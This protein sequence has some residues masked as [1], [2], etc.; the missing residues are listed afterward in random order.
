M[1]RRWLLVSLP[2][3]Q[4]G[5]Q[6][7]GPAMPPPQPEIVVGPTVHVSTAFGK[8]SHTEVF[9]AAH[10]SIPGLLLACAMRGRAAYDSSR[11]GW[12]D[13]PSYEV[14]VYRSADGGA[15]WAPTLD[16]PGG[17]PSCVFGH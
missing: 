3:L 10:P 5:G 15:T 1:R 12:L 7:P 13:R 16:F 11:P 8:Q 2:L 14:V 4:L 17:D 6:P 9:L